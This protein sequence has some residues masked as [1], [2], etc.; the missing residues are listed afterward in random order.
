MSCGASPRDHHPIRVRRRRLSN[1]LLLPRALPRFDVQIAPPDLSDWIEGNNGIRG[2]MHIKA[3]RS[4]PHVVLVSLIHGNEYAGAAALD[5][6]LREGIQ[7]KSGAV[8][9]VFANLDAYRRFDADNPTAARFVDEDMN[10]LWDPGRLNST[11]NSVELTRARE[12]LPVIQSADLLLDLHS[13]LWESEP[14]LISPVTQRSQ[15][16]AM[17]L[18][19]HLGTPRLMLTDLG[20]LGGAR[21]IEQSVFLSESGPARSVLLEAGQHWRS[22][23]TDTSLKVAR[24][25]I[26]QAETIH[27]SDDIA[28]AQGLEQAIVTDNVMARSAGFTFR[29]PYR[30]GEVIHRAGTIIAQDGED[31][32]CTPY[33][34]CLLVMPNL[35]AR[36][37]QLAVRLARLL[38]NDQAPG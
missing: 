32:I 34:R 18:A 3:R 20:H 22:E 37:G 8:S 24:R 25:L 26:G 38:R 35:H 15:A 29:H 9:V 1:S 27:F 36:R 11:Q 12:L 23:T 5:R 7:P 31:E 6:L 16:L 19:G 28:G 10:R 33:D 4:G 17:A 2:V 21:L 13:M 14:L 30:G